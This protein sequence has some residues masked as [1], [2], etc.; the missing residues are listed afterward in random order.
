M[1]GHVWSSLNKEATAYCIWH[2]TLTTGVII[3][4]GSSL[5][6]GENCQ[7]EWSPCVWQLRDIWDRF[8]S[9]FFTVFKSVFYRFWSPVQTSPCFTNTVQSVF[10]NMP[11]LMRRLFVVITRTPSQTVCF[12]DPRP[13]MFR[14]RESEGN[15]GVEA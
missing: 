15:I 6:T 2:F 5:E 11:N 9:P 7:K 13:Q 4:C 8:L 14:A 3:K 12:L 1:F 10:Y